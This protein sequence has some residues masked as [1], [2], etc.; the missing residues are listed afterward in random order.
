MDFHGRYENAYLFS[1]NFHGGYNLRLLYAQGDREKGEGLS[2][3]Q[4]LQACAAIANWH[5]ADLP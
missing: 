3:R 4:T 5:Y 2:V 1:V